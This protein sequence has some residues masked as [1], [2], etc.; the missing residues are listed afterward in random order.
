MYEPI[1]HG[2]IE[3]ALRLYLTPL[4]DAHVSVTIPNPRPE[5]LVIVPRIGGT[6][7]DMVTESATIAVECWDA[8]PSDALSLA[9]EARAHIHALTGQTI[10]GL[11]VYRTQE[12]A[13][14]AMLPDPVSELPRY[15]FTVSVDVR[16]TAQEVPNG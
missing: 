5:R 10:S 3:D 16:G 14:P 13:G 4:L 6:K 7:R 8:K 9:Q 1:V 15:V 2:D 11:T 12:F